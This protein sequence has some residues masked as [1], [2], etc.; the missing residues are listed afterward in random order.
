MAQS[1][2]ANQ[3][4]IPTGSGEQILTIGLNMVYFVAGIIAVII[5]IVAGF[6]MMTASEPAT[7]SKARDSILHAVAAIV[8]ILAAFTI[9]HYIL[10]RF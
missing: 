7:I 4:H 3:I 9:T 1:I 10:G 6:K 5:I 2:S 8:I